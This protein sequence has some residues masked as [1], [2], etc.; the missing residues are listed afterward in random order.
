MSTPTILNKFLPPWWE[1]STCK[2]LY[3]PYK[4]VENVSF[5]EKRRTFMECLNDI[6]KLNLD[7]TKKCGF[8][9][10]SIIQDN[11]FKMYDIPNIEDCIYDSEGYVVDEETDNDNLDMDYDDEYVTDDCGSDSEDDGEWVDF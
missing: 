2:S 11:P 6:H 9:S 8:P 3:I 1:K 10:Y 7:Y 5:V 4:K